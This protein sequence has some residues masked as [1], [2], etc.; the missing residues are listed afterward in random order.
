MGRSQ[1]PGS[2]AGDKLLRAE[3]GSGDDAGARPPLPG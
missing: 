1:E 2:A 3:A